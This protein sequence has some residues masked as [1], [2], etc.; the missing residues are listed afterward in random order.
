MAAAAASAPPAS[1][2]PVVEGLDLKSK[3]GLFFNERTGD[4]LRLGV[5]NGR[6]TFDRLQ[7]GDLM[8]YDGDGDRRVDHVDIYIG[9]GYALDSSS[10]PGGV[11]PARPA[12]RL[13]P[14]TIRIPAGTSSG[15]TFKVKVVRV[16]NA[17]QSSL[18][19]RAVARLELGEAAVLDLGGPDALDRFSLAVGRPTRV[20]R[21]RVLPV[22]GAQRA[23]RPDQLEQPGRG[24]GLSFGVGR[25]EDRAIGLDAVALAVGLA[26]AFA[27]VVPV[28]ADRVLDAVY[29]E[30]TTL[31]V[32]SIPVGKDE[33]LREWIEIEAM[34][35]EGASPALVDPSQLKQDTDYIEIGNTGAYCRAIAGKFNGYGV[36][37]EAILHDEIDK[38]EELAAD[39]GMAEVPSAVTVFGSARTGRDHPEY[40]TG[41]D[42]GACVRASGVRSR[43]STG[44]TCGGAGT[45]RLR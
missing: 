25:A 45:F 6:L 26:F 15:R 43:R 17:I 27:P 5:D 31:G 30:T 42:L 20:D 34:F 18:S 39:S 1:A 35:D 22:E 11:T 12:S 24:A 4:A 7:P 9:N 3:T 19:P 38:L 16:L 2:A 40:Q 44:T 8:F 36:Y 41:R 21:A 23:V 33:L 14:V 37:E 28:A 13:E 29:R 32:R 10:T